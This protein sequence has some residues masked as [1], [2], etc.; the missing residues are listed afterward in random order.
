MHDVI[1]VMK[2]GVICSVAGLTIISQTLGMSSMNVSAASKLKVT[3]SSTSLAGKTIQIKKGS[4]VK[5]KIRQKGVKGKLKVKSKSPKVATIKKNGKITAKKIGSA[6]ITIKKGK[7]TVSF[8]VKVIKKGKTGISSPKTLPVSYQST[9][10]AYQTLNVKVG[11]Q[12]Q[13]KIGGTGKLNI[14]VK[15]P[16]IARISSQGILSALLVGSTKATIKRGSKKAEF[17]IHVKEAGT[18]SVTESKKMSNKELQSI[19]DGLVTRIAAMPDV[20]SND[21]YDAYKDQMEALVA[22]VSAAFD[23]GV[24]KAMIGNYDKYETLELTY[25]GVKAVREKKIGVKEQAEKA[26]AAIPEI[27]RE[28][29]DSDE[30]TDALSVANMYLNYVKNSGIDVNTVAGYADYLKKSEMPQMFTRVLNVEDMINNLPEPGAV[31]FAKYGYRSYEDMISDSTSQFQLRFDVMAVACQIDAL[32]EGAAYLTNL[33]KYTKINDMLGVID[34]VGMNGS[35]LLYEA[36][37]NKAKIDESNIL[38]NLPRAYYISSWYRLLSSENTTIEDTVAKECQ[39]VCAIYDAYLST[40]SSTDELERT[41]LSVPEYRADVLAANLDSN[42]ASIVK[43]LESL[44]Q[45]SGTKK[46]ETDAYLALAYDSIKK[47]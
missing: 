6:K 23:K 47:K 4:S 10:I 20:I 25:T 39:R 44:L 27:T 18:T 17:T 36:L 8:T 38:A 26:I 21:N 15:D 12:I 43:N 33:D 13:L 37:N 14:S 46:I 16:R 24:T 42:N 34:Q 29:Y 40:F 32:K 45:S 7:K 2:N 19:A 41:I 30:V 3:Y 28:N 11:D 9:P 1:R 5:V 22:D 31:T 35:T